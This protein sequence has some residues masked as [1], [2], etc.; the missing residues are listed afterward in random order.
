[1]KDDLHAMDCTSAAHDHQGGLGPCAACGHD[2]A[3]GYAS[4]WNERDGERWFCHDDDH[5]CYAPSGFVCCDLDVYLGPKG[6]L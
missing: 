5:S 3:C 6:K 2:P 4:T 1:M